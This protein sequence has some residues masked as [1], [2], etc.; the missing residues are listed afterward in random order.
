MLTIG[1]SHVS[2]NEEIFSKSSLSLGIDVFCSEHT[3]KTTSFAHKLSPKEASILSSISANSC[4]FNMPLGHGMA[5]LA[6]IIDAG[7]AALNAGTAAVGFM[8]TAY[9]SFSIFFLLSPCSI[10]TSVPLIPGIGSVLYMLLV[11]PLLASAMA[12]T[13]SGE[14]SMAVVP[15]K[16]EKSISFARGERPRLCFY[17]LAKSLLPAAMSQLLYLISFGS[18]LIEFDS[19]L[20][21]DECGLMQTS[22]EHAIR[23]E[24]LRSYVGPSV[25]SSGALI[26]AFQTLCMIAISSSFL[27]GTTPVYTKPSPLG[28]NNIWLGANLLCILLIVLYLSVTLEN[29]TLKALPWYFYFL[30]LIFPLVCLAECE[31]VKRNEKKHEQRAAKMRRLHFETRL[32]M[33]SPK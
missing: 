22:W 31:I 17:I 14:D 7:R 8:V 18:L 27:L 23:C 13:E 33:W 4:I 16:N 11:V 5:Q 1:L 6:S 15:M 26:I 3:D 10:S 12:F 25:T 29:G 2:R 30:S 32:G 28:K 9:I 24:A 20:I 19:K 21:L